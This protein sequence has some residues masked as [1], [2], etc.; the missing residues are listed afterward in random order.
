[1]HIKLPFEVYPGQTIKHQGEEFFVG[2]GHLMNSQG[3]MIGYTYEYH[4][5]SDEIT[6]KWLEAIGFEPAKPYAYNWFKNTEREGVL[7]HFAGKDAKNCYVK[8]VVIDTSVNLPTPADR[9]EFINLCNCFGVTFKPIETIQYPAQ[10]STAKVEPPTE[11]DLD[12]EPEPEDEEETIDFENEDYFDDEP[13]NEEVIE[14]ISDIAHAMFGAGSSPPE[15]IGKLNRFMLAELEKLAKDLQDP[16]KRWSMQQHLETMPKLW[17]QKLAIIGI[18]KK[19]LQFKVVSGAYK[20]FALDWE[21]S[22]SLEIESCLACVR[23]QNGILIEEHFDSIEEATEFCQGFHE[24]HA[25][26]RIDEL[27]N[28]QN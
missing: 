9:E 4:D 6:F 17:K 5:K 2:A 10:V 28:Q 1:M 7:L 23:N 21:Y 27:M 20:A 13:E 16:N 26:K 3:R 12:D 15:S 19:P 14:V 11:I 8:D 24:V 18:A 25:T 22:I